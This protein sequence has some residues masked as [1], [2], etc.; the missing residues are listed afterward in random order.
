MQSPPALPPFRLLHA[1]YVTRELDR[2]IDA[3]LSLFGCPQATIERRRGVRIDTPNGEVTIDYAAITAEGVTLEA[4]EPRGGPDEFYT[5]ALN[6][7]ADQPAFHHLASR[8]DSP[9][10]WE[11]LMREAARRGI[12]LLVHGR[13]GRVDYAY[14]DLRPWC[15]HITEY[16]HFG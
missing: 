9:A 5:R 13:M 16:L 10:E 4:I 3:L 15:G 8:I 7:S 12:P 14:L 11:A 2:G 1:C 6:P